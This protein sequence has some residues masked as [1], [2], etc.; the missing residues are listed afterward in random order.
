VTRLRG[1]ARGGSTEGPLGE[2]VRAVLGSAGWAETAPRTAGAVRERW[3]SLA[4]LVTL[5]DEL[6][7]D[8]ADS[9]PAFVSELD[10]RAE[11]QHAPVAA[12]VTLASIHAAKGLEWRVVFVV[13]C[14]D[15]LLPL[16]Y[17]DTP[18]QVEE[19]RRLAYVALTRAADHL[20]L[21]WSRSRQPGGRGGRTPSRFLGEALA[22]TGTT[23]DAASGGVVRRGSG[24]ARKEVSRKGPA[25][26]RVCSKGL[27]TPQERTLGRC[28]GCPSS[29]DEDLLA[30]L[31]D[32][33]LRV[34]KQRRVPA[35]TVL[36]D[37]TLTAIAEQ[38][39]AD[40]EALADIPGLG[41]M[42]LHAYGEA[43]LALIHRH[44]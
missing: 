14:S 31:R 19:E 25:K 36:T 23:V 28:S 20:H 39:P 41:P 2:G 33:R 3:E 17:A 37:T 38:L 29:L 26:C 13:G 10:A 34:S 21:S 5:A 18:G 8:L 16:Q 9:L 12:G 42:K 4:A 40:S 15:G 11:L 30:E 6:A 24:K 35:F 44:T 32:W 1:A 7:D 27:V 43:I 22:A